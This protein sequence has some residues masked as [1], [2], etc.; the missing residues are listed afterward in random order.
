MALLLGSVRQAVADSPDGKVDVDQVQHMLPTQTRSSAFQLA[1]RVWAGDGA[2][3]TRLLRLMAQRE[4]GVAVSV[5]A[6]LSHGLRMIA[7]AGMAKGN[8]GPHIRP[9]QAKRA[10][11]NAR[12]WGATGERIA[13]L[14]VRLPI[15]DVQMKGSLDGAM[16]LD[17]EQK[18]AIL[19]QEIDRL[20][21]LA[22]N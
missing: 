18:M 14:A 8:P 12:T 2:E 6:A 11:E 19:E 20:A 3:A 4:R 10:R 5:V 7:L 17:D 1:D 21:R 13:R 22:E 15:L 16:A 9:W